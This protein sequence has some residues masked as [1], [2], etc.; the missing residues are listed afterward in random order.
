MTLDRG[1]RAWRV[2][3]DKGRSVAGKTSDVVLV[4]GG[5]TESGKDRRE[6]CSMGK[7]H[8]FGWICGEGGGVSAIVGTHMS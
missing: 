4:K 5:G 8:E 7:G 1:D 3:V 2:L 6:E